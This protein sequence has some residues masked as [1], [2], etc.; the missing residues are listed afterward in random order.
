MSSAITVTD[1][2]AEDP[3]SAFWAGVP[4]AELAAVEQQLAV[5]PNWVLSKDVTDARVAEL[6]VY[7]ES[8]NREPRLY[9]TE[10]RQAVEDAAA[11]VETALGRGPDSLS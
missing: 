9:L 8:P 5:S 7:I 4:A 3:Y 2:S 11:A 10:T 6:L 1:D